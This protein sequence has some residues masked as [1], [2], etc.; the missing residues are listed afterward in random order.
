MY[1]PT[2][3][4]PSPPT[5]STLPKDHPFA[6]YYIPPSA[7][8]QNQTTQGHIRPSSSISSITTTSS[9]P[10]SPTSIKNKHRSPTESLAAPLSPRPKQ[11]NHRPEVHSYPSSISRE[12]ETSPAYSTVPAELQLFDQRSRGNLLGDLEIIVGKKLKFPVLR[13]FVSGKGVDRET[14]TVR[15]KESRKLKKERW[16]EG[17]EW[18]Q[19]I[20]IEKQDKGR[21]IREGNWI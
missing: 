1:Q 21:S 20:V 17:Y 5:N 3:A 13:R 7:Y 6:T 11:V 18:D 14:T 2:Q 15:E 9:Y 16:E 4:A 10:S 19:V 12:R 8:Y